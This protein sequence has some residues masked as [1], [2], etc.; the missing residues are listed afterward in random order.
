MDLTPGWRLLEDHEVVMRGD[1]IAGERTVNKPGPC[2]D[3]WLEADSSVGSKVSEVKQGLTLKYF[4]RRESPK[5][6]EWLNP[7]DT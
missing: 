3:K 7:W 1:R 4:A 2:P 5:E 6:K